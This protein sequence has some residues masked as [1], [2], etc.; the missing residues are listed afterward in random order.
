MN[1]ILIFNKPKGISSHDVVY[2]LR[3]KTG[4]K[5]IGHTGTLDP[6]A[7]G[8]LVMGIA[9][10]TK[11]IEYLSNDTKEY[12]AEIKFGYETDTLDCTGKTINTSNNIPS[13]SDINKTIDKFIGNISQIPPMYSAIK[14][15]GQKLYN[16]ARA[17][18]VID[19]EPRNVYIENL[20]LLE[21][22]DNN[23]FKMQITCSSGTYVRSLIRDIG[24]ELETYATME[25]LVRTK[26]GKFDIKN[27]I[28]SEELNCMGIEELES[29]IISIPNALDH[30]SSINLPDE[31]YKNIVNGVKYKCTLN[32][33]Y[34]T[35]FKIYCCNKFIGVGSYEKKDG[36]NLISIKK[37][38][39]G[40]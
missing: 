35:F 32:Y 26:A 18:K 11:I 29:K 4:I 37:Q 39:M 3:K 33:P 16:L 8:V 28:T 22:I 15:N 36:T 40:E 23:T 38:L 5:K 27:A 9:K 2:L 24:H 12:I 19:I 20:E 25:N 31:F 34:G 21:Q 17:G 30:M 13:I 1:G 7:T 10:G 14:V 6:L